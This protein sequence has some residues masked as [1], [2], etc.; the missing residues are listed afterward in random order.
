MKKLGWLLT[1]MVA[2][3]GAAQKLSAQQDETMAPVRVARLTYFAGAVDVA[4]ADNT[5]QDEPVMNMPLSEG[6]RLITGDYGQ[7]EVEFE[8]GSLLRITPRSTVALARLELESGV[9]RTSMTVLGGLVY[10]ELRKSAGYSYTVS[11]GGVTLSPVENAVVRV[12]LPDG[13]AVFSVVSGS[14]RVE[15]GFTA[16]I[17]AG[18]S[19]HADARDESRYFLTEQ[20]PLESW[21]GWNEQRDR[22]AADETERRTSARDGFAGVQGYG[23][24]DLDAN[25][26]W[27]DV[28][29]EGQVWQPYAADEQ[30]DPYGYGGWVWQGVGYVWASGYQWGW[31]PYRCGRWDF[32]PG[33]GW[34]W[35]PDNRCGRWGSGGGQVLLGRRL[36]PRYKVIPVPLRTPVKVHPILIVHS[37]DGPRPPLHRGH[38]ST[39]QEI[40][41]TKWTPLARL[42]GVPR[43]GP[44]LG[45]SRDYPVNPSTHL[46]VV[47]KVPKEESRTAPAGGTASDWRAIRPEPIAPVG[48]VLSQRP[49]E[50]GD[51]PVRQR[52]GRSAPASPGSATAPAMPV[53][54]IREPVRNSTPVQ[55]PNHP[56]APA[57]PPAQPVQAPKPAPAPAPAP[58]YHPPVPA[59]PAAAPAKAP[60]NKPQ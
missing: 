21:D 55:T 54:T 28:A 48:G 29:G 6:T 26:T 56:M 14:V 31:T 58:V 40:H 10:F 60:T 2:C 38:D 36:P 42:G 33:F 22:E 52:P 1:L 44:T 50:N 39:V 13:P 32:F 8:D 7:A 37:P 27:Y 57:T 16:E 4:R 25:G 3:G 59:P 49:V 51:E 41:G 12:S 30:F 24:S 46:A 11:A 35:L 53:R 20:I 23:W 19:L 15:K 17:H 45:L 34:G 47:G 18:E 9:A 43:T 5:G